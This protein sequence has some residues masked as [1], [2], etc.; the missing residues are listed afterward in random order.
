[1]RDCCIGYSIGHA[2]Q[3]QALLGEVLSLSSEG[4]LCCTF[5]A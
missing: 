2:E 1:M 5:I 3:G 4:A